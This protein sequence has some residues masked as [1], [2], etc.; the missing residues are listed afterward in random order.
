MSNFMEVESSTK[1]IKLA[2]KQNKDLNREDVSII[3]CHISLLQNILLEIEKQKDVELDT[4]Y[5]SK[6]Q[7]IKFF[8][9]D[10][11]YTISSEEC[12]IERSFKVFN[13]IITKSTYWDMNAKQI[14]FS[15]NVTGK[16]P[17]PENLA[18]SILNYNSKDVLVFLGYGYGYVTFDSVVLSS[19]LC[20][21]FIIE[22]TKSCKED[23]SEKKT[24]SPGEKKCQWESACMASD[25]D[26]KYISKTPVMKF[27]IALTEKDCSIEPSIENFELTF[28][29]LNSLVD[30]GITV[31]TRNSKHKIRN[32]IALFELITLNT[33]FTIMALPDGK[34]RTFLHMLKNKIS[35]D[36]FFKHCESTCIGN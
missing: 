7:M 36:I 11:P 29:I 20:K 18:K 30:N 2:F 25:V 1:N 10:L 12:F 13:I 32:K 16:V 21:R 19:D 26:T 6:E 23:Q 9:N 31:S 3:K 14:R 4:T 5:I 24:N 22:W 35:C 34:E 15:N 28:K 33:D 17:M 8:Y 27:L